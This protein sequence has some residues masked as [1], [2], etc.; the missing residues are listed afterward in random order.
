MLGYVCFK[1]SV[2][3]EVPRLVQDSDAL[4]KTIRQAL[5][6]SLMTSELHMFKESDPLMLMIEAFQGQVHRGLVWT[7]TGHEAM[8]SQID[9]V[10]V[11]YENVSRWDDQLLKMSV[12]DVLSREPFASTDNQRVLVVH[13]QTHAIT[14]F[15]KMFIHQA[16]GMCV[17]DSNGRIIADLNA[18]DLEGLADH[19]LNILEKLVLEFLSIVHDGKIP[20]VVLCYRS[21]PLKHLV[22]RCVKYSTHR[23]LVQ[24]AG[25]KLEGIVTL[26]DVIKIFV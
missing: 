17:V 11:L 12:G 5:D 22:E 21:T 18:S 3:D 24:N 20:E 8:V 1:K 9:L 2:T 19:D 26:S 15:K 13:D 25:G 6:D 4:N 23:V 14:A 7:E 16:D 10:R